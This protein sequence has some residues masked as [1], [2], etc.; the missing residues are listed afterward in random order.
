MRGHWRNRHSLFPAAS[1]PLL[2]DVILV[3][4]VDGHRFFSLTLQSGSTTSSRRV[5]KL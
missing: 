5:A 1:V 3:I 4:S 2:E